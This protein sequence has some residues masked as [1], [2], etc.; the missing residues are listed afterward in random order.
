M[1]EKSFN[2]DYNIDIDTITEEEQ[3]RIEEFIGSLQEQLRILS[4]ELYRELEE[5]YNYM[6]S[7]EAII[8]FIE[9]NEYFFN[10]KGEIDY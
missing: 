7:D 2:L 6:Q 10:D 1:H 3:S 5:D 4:K 8:D 9:L